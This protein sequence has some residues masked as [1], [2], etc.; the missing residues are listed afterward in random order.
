MMTVNA[1]AAPLVPDFMEYVESHFRRELDSAVQEWSRCTRLLAEW[2]NEHLLNHPAQ[3]LS[4]R[5]RQAVE[6]LLR[7]GKYLLL[8]TEQ[9]GVSNQQARDIV[10][11]TQSCLQD[12]L[13]LWHG[14]TLTD[15]GRSEILTAC[16]N[17]S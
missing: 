16:F 2:E 8:A 1:L 14:Q 9:S 7:F 4:A 10:R 13:S 12:K 15:Q 17:E 6:R 3:E 5:H 11:A